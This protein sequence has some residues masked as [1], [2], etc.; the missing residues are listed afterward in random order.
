MSIASPD[1]VLSINPRKGDRTAVQIQSWLNSIEAELLLPWRLALPGV[2]IPPTQPAD[3]IEII[4]LA[5]QFGGAAMLE[6]APVIGASPDQMSAS[7][8]YYFTQ[9]ESR[10]LYLANLSGAQLIALGVL[11]T[12]SE[13][14][15]ASADLG[16]LTLAHHR[17]PL[18]QDPYD[19]YPFRKLT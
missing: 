1:D 14:V 4:K 12:P 13:A 17:G 7:A 3:L 6:G 19:A 16:G 9:Y 2:T 15:A 5:E 10:R 11:Y 18:Y 8:N